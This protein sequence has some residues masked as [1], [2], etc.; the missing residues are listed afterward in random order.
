[1]FRSGKTI[2][3]IAAERT[4]AKSTIESHLNRYV[5][6]GE[7]KLNELLSAEKIQNILQFMAE[8]PDKTTGEIKYLMGDTVTYADLRFVK[9]H[10]MFMENNP[11]IKGQK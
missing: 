1:M 7:I 10:L 9:Q 4:L 8:N 3:E 5:G 6:S 11:G 2:A